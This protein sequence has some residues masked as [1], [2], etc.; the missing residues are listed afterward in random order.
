MAPKLAKFK[1]GKEEKEKSNKMETQ[2]SPLSNWK[3]G[4]LGYRY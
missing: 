3:K 4:N 2:I 1:T